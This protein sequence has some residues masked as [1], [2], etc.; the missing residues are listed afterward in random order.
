M[1]RT[2][3]AIAHR[4]GERLLDKDSGVGQ[5]RGDDGDGFDPVDPG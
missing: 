5:Y 2:E 1:T 3:I 4:V